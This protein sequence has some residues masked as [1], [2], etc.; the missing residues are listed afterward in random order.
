MTDLLL[1]KTFFFS[2]D[3]LKKTRTFFF[4]RLV[5]EKI[6]HPHLA[7]RLIEKKITQIHALARTRNHCFD[8]HILYRQDS[9]TNSAL[10]Q[11]PRV[12]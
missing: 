6:S 11:D 7:T 3:K 5:S 8:Q 4:E 1:S 2:K 10:L 9:Y 12:R